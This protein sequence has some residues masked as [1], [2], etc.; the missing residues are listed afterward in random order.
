M[1]IGIIGTGAY[2]LA[3]GLTINENNHDVTMWTKFDNEKEELEKTRENKKFLPNIKIP[4]SIHFT[5]NLNDAIIDKDIIFIAIPA[6]FVDDISK[7]MKETLK[8][9]QCVCIASKGIEQDTCLFVEDVFKKYN[10]N[11]HNIAVISG[12]SFA[13]DIASKMPI[14]LSLASKNKKSDLLVKNALQN[15]HFKLRTSTDI[16]G[17][18]ICG[19]IK[20]VIAIASGILDG[21]NATESTKAM[22]ITESLHDIKSLIRK[23]GGKP[24]TIL[25][26]AGFGDLLLTCTSDKSRNFSFGKLIGEHTP[27]KEIDEYINTHTIEG[28]YT[29]KSIYKLINNKNVDMPIIDLI[30]NIIFNN[31]KP[32]AL[33]T[34]LIEKE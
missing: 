6:M 2:G 34:F 27:K 23:L 25:A 4:E 8:K 7:S 16:L 18:E 22:F 28:L 12:P 1:K 30:Y 3:L 24:K 13:S 29:L 26:F 19:S 11:H 32:D 9:E 10:K 20:N 21:L 5:T 14:G 17:T 15:S 31:E 33:L